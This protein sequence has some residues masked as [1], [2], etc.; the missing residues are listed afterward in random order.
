MSE[1]ID[2]LLRENARLKAEL[3]KI[4]SKKTLSNKRG[5]FKFVGTLIA[6]KNLKKSIYNSINEF[7][8]QRKISIDTTS[9]LIASLIRRITRI[10][11]IGLLVA[12]L[13]TTLMFYQNNLLKIQNSKIE[14]QTHLAEASRR[15]TQMFIM[16]EVLSD[17]NIE[18]KNSGSSRLS[19]TLAGRIIGLSRA[20]KPYRYMVGDKLINEPISPERGQLLISLCKSKIAPSFFV[21]EI[22]QE[23]DFTKSELIDAKLRGATLRDINLNDANLSGSD[24]MNVDLQNASLKN[25]NLSYADLDDANLINANLEGAN[26]KGAFLIRTNLKGANLSGTILDSVKV[27]RADWLVYIK[28]KLKIKGATDLF[29]TYKIDSVYYY[30]TSKLKKPMVLRR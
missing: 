6:G 22:L 1:H 18:L 11:V 26:L 16:G 27:D 23:S 20:M 15:S 21:D 3:E 17:V 19:N 13:P 25:T 14:T 30:K 5:I 24:L 2:D 9:N 10:G 28:D 8:E 12:I 4:N 7:N 29:E